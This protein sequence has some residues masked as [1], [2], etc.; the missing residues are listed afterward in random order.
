MWGWWLLLCLDPAL[1]Y[2]SELGVF[3]SA[4]H[5]RSFWMPSTD[6]PQHGEEAAETSG[7]FQ[8]GGCFLKCLKSSSDF[9]G[10]ET[11]FIGPF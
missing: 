4:G 11:H 3:D 9:N 10:R 6:A 7:A 5:V 8:A 1:K 2:M